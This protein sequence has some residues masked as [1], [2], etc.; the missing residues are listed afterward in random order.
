VNS[1]LLC[2]VSNNLQHTIT[3]KK[4]AAAAS[5]TGDK[6]VRRRIV[7]R[8]GF[9]AALIDKVCRPSSTHRDLSRSSCSKLSLSNALAIRF[10][11]P[12]PSN[13][14]GLPSAIRSIISFFGP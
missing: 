10:K 9:S 14:I 1:F 2:L 11:S 6:R 4:D 12:S 13:P 5:L 8:T 7:F 3:K